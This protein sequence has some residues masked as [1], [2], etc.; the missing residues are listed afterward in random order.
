MSNED[1]SDPG[2]GNSPAAWTGVTIVFIGFVVAVA[3]F[4]FNSLTMFIVAVALVAG[5]P[6]VGWILAK[7]GW[8]VAGPRYQSKSQH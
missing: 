7:A 6:L 3:A 8:G 5:G 2:H 1:I 4:W